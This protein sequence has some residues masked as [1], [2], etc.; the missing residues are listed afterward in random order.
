VHQLNQ[1]AAAAVGRLAIRVILNMFL[2][3]KGN[4]EIKRHVMNF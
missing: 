1:A 2:C 3:A 4:K